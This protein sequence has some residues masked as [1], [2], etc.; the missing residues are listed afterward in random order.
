MAC[1]KPAVFA[2]SLG[3]SLSSERKSPGSCRRRN[4]NGVENWRK[5]KVID[6]SS[7]LGIAKK[8]TPS[9]RINPRTTGKAMVA[10]CSGQ[11]LAA[12]CSGQPWPGGGRLSACK[13]PAEQEVIDE[14]TSPSGIR[15]ASGVA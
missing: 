15:A 12:D 7:R 9:D 3:P 8:Q 2:P 10:P 4:R 13:R 14:P 1:P 6:P 11:A 5:Q